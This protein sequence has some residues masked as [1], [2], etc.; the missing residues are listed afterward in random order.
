MLGHSEGFQ[1]HASF[2]TEI[3][4]LYPKQFVTQTIKT[5][6]EFD[7][8]CGWVIWLI[9]L[10]HTELRHVFQSYTNKSFPS[11]SFSCL[12]MKVCQP[13]VYAKYIVHSSGMH[14]TCLFLEQFESWYVCSHQNLFKNFQKISKPTSYTRNQA[15][16]WLKYVPQ[17]FKIITLLKSISSQ[18][19]TWH[20]G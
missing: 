1:E 18:C 14:Y 17:N 5:Q 10:F 20:K 12:P 15:I 11:S 3:T 19:K 8:S 6:D 4:G 16:K 9:L 2:P 13:E 7:I